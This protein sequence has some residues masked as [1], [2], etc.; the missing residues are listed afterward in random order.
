MSG[1]RHLSAA[2]RSTLRAWASLALYVAAGMVLEL[3]GEALAYYSMGLALIGGW[4]AGGEPLIA[5]ISTL[6]HVGEG[7]RGPQTAAQPRPRI[8]EGD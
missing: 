2:R 5:A 3:E 4:A 8:P 6:R 1:S 7:W